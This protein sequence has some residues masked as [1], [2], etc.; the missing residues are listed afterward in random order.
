MKDFLKNLGLENITL[1]IRKVRT[2]RVSIIP[3][4][5]NVLI[6]RTPNVSRV[7]NY[8]IENLNWI[9]NVF[10]NYN[11]HP[12]NLAKLFETG[13]V[14]FKGKKTPCIKEEASINRVYFNG[15]SFIIKYRVSS[16]ILNIIKKKLKKLAKEEFEALVK[17]EAKRLNI[18]F[19]RLRVKDT[20][21]RW[22]SCSSNRNINL[23]WRLIMAPTYV[24]NYVI[25]H[26]LI[27][28]EE[29]NHYKDFWNKVKLYYPE[30]KEAK[31]WLKKHGIYLYT[32]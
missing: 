21:T 16:D 5:N 24:Y 8:V 30:F 6:I 26:E 19:N 31:D 17:K 13:F 18:G 15:E 20:K 28:I 1:V 4:P 27:H 32:I 14:M 2:N 25:I 3:T 7:K 23:S 29:P 12:L 9:K 10:E 22:G 11:Q